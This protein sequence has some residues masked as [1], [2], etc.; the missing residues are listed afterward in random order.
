[1]RYHFFTI[2]TYLYGDLELNFVI[3]RKKYKG[4]ARLA[5]LRL[6]GECIFC[7]VGKIKLYIIVLSLK[8][9]EIMTI[10]LETSAIAKTLH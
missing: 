9:V 4:R 1:M 5:S 7:E 6:L 3:Y 10:G 2:Q 8:A